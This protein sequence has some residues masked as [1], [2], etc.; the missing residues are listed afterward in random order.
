[1][2][3]RVVRLAAAGLLAGMAAAAVAA[4]PPGGPGQAPTVQVP[5]RGS[6]EVAFSPWNDP[7]AAL[8]AAI[9]EARESILVQAYVFTSKPVA[10]ALI[11]AHKRGL[12]VEVLLDA[13]MNRPS[14]L[15]VLP[16]L[17]EAGIPVAV[18][19][20]YNIAH[21]KVIILDPASANHGAVVTGSYNFT[22]SARVA[23]A[24]NLLI[25]RGNPALVRIYTDN[26]QRHR[27]EAQLL[28]SLG[29]LPPRRGK[30]NGRESDRG[31]PG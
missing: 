25:L 15:S 27:A 4:D 1:M 29:D 13:E 8:I 26:W 19:T 3:A 7:E 5:A 11:A 24:E 20:R 21:N 17:M 9:G 22:R 6:V 14:S 18:E 16:Q 28:R 10:R 23:N 2:P 31:T 30:T 12:R